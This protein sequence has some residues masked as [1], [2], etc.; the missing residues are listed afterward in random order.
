[1]LVVSTM[2]TATLVLVRYKAEVWRSARNI[3]KFLNICVLGV[4]GTSV[5]VSCD[6]L[7]ETARNKQ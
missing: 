2:N 7:R 4:A 1:M 5:G 6:T 3:F